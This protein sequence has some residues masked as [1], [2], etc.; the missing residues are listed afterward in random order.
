MGFSFPLAREALMQTETIE[1]AT[2]WLLM[3]SV[4][5]EEDQLM[6]AISLSLSLETGTEPAN[7]SAAGNVATTVTTTPGRAIAN[8]IMA[9][10]EISGATTAQPVE[11]VKNL[12]IIFI[13]YII[14]NIFIF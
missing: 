12:R 3:H 6:R 7:T 10:V 13:F 1:A 5:N 2:E 8:A 14:S 11:V 4:P 9:A